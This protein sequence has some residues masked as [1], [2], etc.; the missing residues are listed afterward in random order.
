MWREGLKILNLVVI[1][2]RLA[3]DASFCLLSQQFRPST[4]LNIAAPTAPKSSQFAEEYSSTSKA[5]A[6][7]YGCL[8]N[9]STAA[10]ACL[11]SADCGTP[12]PRWAFRLNATN[13]ARQVLHS[14]PVS[15]RRG[16]NRLRLLAKLS[17]AR[18]LLSLEFSNMSAS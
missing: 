15:K 18:C 2:G 16:G 14:P 1:S 7:S 6:E 10:L 11:P 12:L 5:T 4:V 17:T 9:C 3:L 13:S 8:N